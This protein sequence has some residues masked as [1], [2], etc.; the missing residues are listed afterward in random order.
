MRALYPANSFKMLL[1]IGIWAGAA[2][3]CAILL[4][5]LSHA[6]DFLKALAAMWRPVILICVAGYLLFFNDQGRELG[7]SLLGERYVWPLVFLFLALMYWA[8]NTWHTARL[9]LEGALENGVLGVAPSQRSADNPDRR[10]AGGGERWLY[11]PPRLLGVFAHLF[12][13]INLSLA[14]WR[15]PAAAWGEPGGLRWL[16]W[17]AP[18]AILLATA[19]VWAEDRMRSSRGRALSSPAGDRLARWVSRGAFAGEVVLLGALATLGVFSNHVPVGFVP[20][21]ITISISAM[22]FLGLISWLRNR[23][24]PL[25][26]DATVEAREADDQRQRRQI[27][28]F[29]VGLFLVA[30]LVGVAV[31]ISPTGVGRV[32][33]LDGRR[34]FRVRRDSG[35]HQHVRV[36]G[37]AGD[38]KRAFGAT[39][40]LRGIGAYALAFVIAVGVVNAWLHP[41]HRVRLCDGDCVPVATPDQRPTVAAAAKAWY[42]QAKSAYDKAHGEGPVPML[43]VA[44]AG[45]GIRAGYW[46][47]TV[48]EQL[49]DRFQGSRRRAAPISSPS[50]ASP[51]AASAPRRSRRR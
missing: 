41:F 19:L 23:T 9:G 39:A 47:A 40:T 32:S 34:L 49:D 22:V 44:T 11:W 21:T 46:T 31:W 7:V 38:R 1:G 20:A 5:A 27:A 42:A 37:G 13:A 10:V 15:V 33:R 12:A 48:L 50:A 2:A 6:H 17:T 29:T 30:L 24:P 16:A 25:G 8:A 28:A 4:K 18:L 26:P 43:I 45:G 3:A 36:R 14:A 35:A 51:A